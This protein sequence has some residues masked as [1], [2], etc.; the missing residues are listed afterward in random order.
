MRHCYVNDKL[1]LDEAAVRCHSPIRQQSRSSRPLTVVVVGAELPLM[2][3]KTADYA[4]ARAG[5]GLPVVF[6]EIPDADH[7]SI[8]EDMARG[9]GRLVNMLRDVIAGR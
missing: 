5:R 2:Y 6:R 9:D 8:L 3:Q 1:G 4:A 7:F